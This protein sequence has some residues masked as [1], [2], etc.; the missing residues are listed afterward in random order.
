LSCSDVCDLQQKRKAPVSIDPLF[1]IFVL[2]IIAT[3]MKRV[4]EEPKQRG[5]CS[6]Y[7]RLCLGKTS[8]EVSCLLRLTCDKMLALARAAKLPSLKVFAVCQRKEDE[9]EPVLF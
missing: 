4:M 9:K 7:H 1:F 5:A 8:H 6:S 3:L 2:C